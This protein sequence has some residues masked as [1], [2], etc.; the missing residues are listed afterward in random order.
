MIGFGRESV[1]NTAICYGKFGP[2]LESITMFY[3]KLTDD[4][5][6]ITT[7][8]VENSNNEFIEKGFIHHFPNHFNKYT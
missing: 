3:N 7:T 5:F 6:D 2:C 8:L 1:V 4:K